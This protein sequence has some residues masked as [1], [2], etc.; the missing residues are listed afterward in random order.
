ML[1]WVKCALKEDCIAPRGSKFYG[2]DFSRKPTF[3]Y[4]GCHRYEMSAFS[5]ITAIM[6]NFEQSIY[7]TWEDKKSKNNATLSENLSESLSFMQKFNENSLLAYVTSTKINEPKEKVKRR[8]QNSM[9]NYKK[10]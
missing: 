5:N 7:T 3:L 9:F 6:F 4:S 8:R 1:P 10:N 2:C